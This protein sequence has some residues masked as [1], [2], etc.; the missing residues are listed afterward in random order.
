MHDTSFG[1][2]FIAVTHRGICSFSFL[3]GTEIN[4]Q[5]SGLLKKW[6]HASIHENHEKTRVVIEAMFSG[7]IKPDRP[8]SLHVSG[9]NFQISVWK[10][11]LQIPS[12]KVVSY[13]QVATVMGRPRSAL[14]V[15]LAV[16]ENPIALL[17]PCHRVIQQ[18]GK[19]GGYRWD[20]T[21][22]HAI[23]VWKVARHEMESSE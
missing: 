20:E 4:E 15:G 7:K 6:P 21:R 8:L 5:L 2:A 11:L 9:T 14:A 13:T 10:A 16:G 3:D 17:N 19:L 12:G 22:K 23:H 18:S 1:K